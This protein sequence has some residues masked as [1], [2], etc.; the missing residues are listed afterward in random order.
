MTGPND[1]NEALKDLR[2]ANKRYE[3]TAGEHERSRLAAIAAVVAALKSGATPT[4]VTRDSPFTDAY[5]RKIARDHGVPPARSGI[6]P[7]RPNP[8]RRS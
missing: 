5:V 2:A 1:P 6:K 3:E 8:R 7:D 4:E